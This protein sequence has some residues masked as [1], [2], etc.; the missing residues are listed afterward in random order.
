MNIND[1]LLRHRELS[2]R[3]NFSILIASLSG[4]MSQFFYDLVTYLFKAIVFGISMLNLETSLEFFCVN[5]F[6]ETQ[7]NFLSG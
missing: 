7:K 4:K 3:S 5:N 1:K 6:A 2:Q